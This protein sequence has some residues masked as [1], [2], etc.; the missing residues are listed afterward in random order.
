M[1]ESSNDWIKPNDIMRCRKYKGLR[2]SISSNISST[3]TA[4]VSRN[5]NLTQNQTPDASA[6]RT[7]KRKNPFSCES[8]YGKIQALEGKSIADQPDLP[9]SRISKSGD[10]ERAFVI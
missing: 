8:Q 2:K 1:A 6:N 4:T 9:N 3:P 7:L 10:K 5:A